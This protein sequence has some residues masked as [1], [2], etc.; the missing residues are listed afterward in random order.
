[1]S[2][3]LYQL[4]YI[5]FNHLQLPSPFFS[6]PLIF[7]FSLFFPFYRP[8]EA[9]S[10]ALSAGNSGSGAVRLRSIPLP[11]RRCG[12]MRTEEQH[13]V[14]FTGATAGSHKVLRRCSSILDDPM[15]TVNARPVALG[16]SARPLPIF[17]LLLFV[18]N[19]LYTTL[20]TL[21]VFSKPCLLPSIH[22]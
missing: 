10:A 18:P 3:T 16:W 21:R 9:D 1:M 2:C 13:S 12:E 15:D 22:V 4:T 20:S 8:R 7:F 5:F 14:P 17:S 19:R 6:S 11:G